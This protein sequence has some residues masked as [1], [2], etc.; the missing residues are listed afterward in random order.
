VN[1][2]PECGWSDE[3]GCTPIDDRGGVCW[4]CMPCACGKGCG[5]GPGSDGVKRCE[6]GMDQKEI[7]EKVEAQL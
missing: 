4:A 2:C 3:D 6:Y 5:F 7:D 1:G